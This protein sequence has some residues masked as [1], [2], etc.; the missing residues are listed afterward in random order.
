MTSLT[1]A[2]EQLNAPVRCP[3]CAA[4]A[5]PT[6]RGDTKEWIHSMSS[7]SGRLVSFSQTGC[8]DRKGLRR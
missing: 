8:V 3:H 4:G 6:F 1:V 7:R 5:E 2:I